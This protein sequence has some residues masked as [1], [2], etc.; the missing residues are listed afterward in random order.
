MPI[1]SGRP[2]GPDAGH[3]YPDSPAP[4]A[5]P[6]RGSDQ[7]RRPTTGRD[8]RRRTSRRSRPCPA[9]VGR[10]AAPRRHAH[11]RRDQRGDPKAT[12]RTAQIRTPDLPQW[13]CHRHGRDRDR[14]RDPAP[15]RAAAPQCRAAAVRQPRRHRRRS[16]RR[17]L[18]GCP[19]RPLR[20]RHRRRLLCGCSCRADHGPR[21]GLRHTKYSTSILGRISPNLTAQTAQYPD[22]VA[23]SPSQLC[24]PGRPFR[25]AHHRPLDPVT[26]IRNRDVY[27][28]AAHSTPLSHCQA[29]DLLCGSALGTMN[30]PGR[31]RAVRRRAGQ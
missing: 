12:C 23:R 8:P 2:A 13:P 27:Q 24:A 20:H 28:V 17:D 4:R 18:T 10:D 16:Q 31:T 22:P 14:D 19:A 26:E 15:R 29:S 6:H 25:R 30:P 11:R 1:N 7:P 3:L 9:L 5:K 21:P